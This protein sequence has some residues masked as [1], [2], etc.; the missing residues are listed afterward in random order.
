MMKMHGTCVKARSQLA[1]TGKENSMSWAT[2]LPAGYWAL[3]WLHWTL[4]LVPATKPWWAKWLDLI[5]RNRDFPRAHDS[6]A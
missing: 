1:E 2:K 6:R 5:L 4:Q 3:Q